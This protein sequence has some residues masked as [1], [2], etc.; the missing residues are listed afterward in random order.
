MNRNLRIYFLRHGLADRNAYDGDDD[1]L[2]PLTAHG[3]ER[4][5]REA[6][7]LARLEL[8]IDVVLTSPLLRAKQT[9]EIVAGRLDLL[10]SL[11]VDDGLG[12]GFGTPELARI[13]TEN[14]EAERFLLVGHE[15]SFSDVISDITGG[16]RVVCKKG[17]LARVDLVAGRKPIGELVWL[18]PPKVLAP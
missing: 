2:R 5:D 15:P 17:G 16:S 4:M 8:R 14:G 1:S 9:A 12:L 11:R 18:L 6:A 13:L 3:K 10:D 7:T